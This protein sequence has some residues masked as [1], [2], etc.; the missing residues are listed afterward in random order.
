MGII[1]VPYHQDERLPDADFPLPAG[2]RRT[3][4]EKELGGGHVWERLA[5]L[6]EPV[7]GIVA[8]EV[9]GGAVPTVV[10]G[11][12]LVSLAM[13]AGLQRAGTEPSLVWFDAHGDVHTMESSTSGYPGGMA[14]RMAVGGNPGLL[15]DRLG[16]CAVPERRAVLVDARD[17]DPAEAEYLASAEIR[18]CGVDEVAS[19]VL[20]DGPLFVHIDVDVIDAGELPGLKFP[21]GGGPGYAAVL[22]AVRRIRATGRVVAVAVSCP[23]HSGEETANG[24]RARLLADLLVTE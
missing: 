8:A 2:L 7:A 13:V 4:V 5:E 24:I 22:S 3:V 9:G 15:A 17:L 20:P 11:D 21:V 1:L 16:L 14:L 12:C 23:W 19:D 10:S 6:Y 18:R